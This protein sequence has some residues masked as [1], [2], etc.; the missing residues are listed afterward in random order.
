VFV[1][2][3]WIGGVQH[4]AL[5][6]NKVANYDVV[7]PAS[8]GKLFAAPPA[9]KGVLTSAALLSSYLLPPSVSTLTN[10]TASGWSYFVGTQ[11][12]QFE[13]AIYPPLSP[14]DQLLNA[15]TYAWQPPPGCPM[16]ARLASAAAALNA[17][18]QNIS[19]T[20]QAREAALAGALPQFTLLDPAKC[21]HWTFT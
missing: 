1:Q 19:T 16:A 21:P 11:V 14:Q 2:V 15:Y 13:F 17:R 7:Y 6:A 20:I 8:P 12:A 3:M 18:L 10:T 9:R 4:H 5:N